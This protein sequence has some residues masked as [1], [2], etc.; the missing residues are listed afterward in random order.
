MRIKNL[1]EFRKSG[2]VLRSFNEIRQQCFEPQ[3]LRA[4]EKIEDVLGELYL[5]TKGLEYYLLQEHQ[6]KGRTFES[7]AQEFGISPAGMYSIAKALNV[8]TISL[9]ERNVARTKTER[10][11]KRE[12][13]SLFKSY[14]ADEIGSMYGVSS[15]TIYT[16]LHEDKIVC[17]KKRGPKK[18]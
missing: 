7:L 3:T 14:N 10:P 12:L 17:N 13:G 2:I 18:Q 6:F 11:S 16:W 15:T 5:K 1:R 9:A 4:Y 8:P